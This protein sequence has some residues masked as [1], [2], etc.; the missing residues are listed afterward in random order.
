MLARIAK[1]P[2]GARQEIRVGDFLGPRNISREKIFQVSVSRWR[3]PANH[4]FH[5]GPQPVAVIIETSCLCVFLI[6]RP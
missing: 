2:S 6:E 4:F 3:F 1:A 5:H